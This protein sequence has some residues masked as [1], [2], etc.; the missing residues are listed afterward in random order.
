[1]KKPACLLATAAA[2]LGTASAMD[3]T[4][5]I[6]LDERGVF[7]PPAPVV[8]DVAA[9]EKLYTP[10][11]PGQYA[12]PGD[13][14]EALKEASHAEGMRFHDGDVAP[15]R[16]QFSRDQFPAS[17]TV[18]GT[19]YDHRAEDCGEAALTG[20][21]FRSCQASVSTYKAGDVASSLRS[22]VGLPLKLASQR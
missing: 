9:L 3:R 1:M 22:L 19:R 21:R 17:R 4:P 7:G 12:A 10:P 2:L 13:F 16:R 20:P 8:I 6:E 18:L 14:V 11:A 15:I 5:I